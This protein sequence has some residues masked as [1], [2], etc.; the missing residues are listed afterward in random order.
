LYLKNEKQVTLVVATHG[1]IPE[2]I[3]DKVFVIENGKLIMK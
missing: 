1:N 3:A 2:K